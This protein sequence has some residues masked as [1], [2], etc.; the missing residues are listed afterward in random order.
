MEQTAYNYRKGLAAMAVCYCIWGFQ[1]LYYAIDTTVDTT[2]LLAC[3]ILWAAVTCLVILWAQGKLQQLAEVFRDRRVLLRELPAS[4]FLFADWAI[5]LFAVRRGRIMECSMGYYIMPLV[6]FVLGAAIFR[7]RIDRVDIA[8]LAFIVVGI[9]LSAG[10]FG[11]FPYVTVLLSVCFAVYSA[12]KK[13]LQ[14]DSIVSTTAEILILA[15]FMLLYLFTLGRGDLALVT[16]AR[17]LF[18]IGSGIVTGLPMVFFAIG[19]RHLP[20]SLTGILQY[21]SPSLALVCS[22]LLGETLTPQ[23]LVSFCFIWAGMV[24][25]SLHELKSRRA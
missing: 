23:K 13:S 17:Q 4:V 25:Y 19:L 24:I 3:R 21:L 11:G 14:I 20:L 5:Y 8:A 15:P 18:L 22:L 7:E 1:P 12:L 6:M 2:F 10:G 9:I 16:A